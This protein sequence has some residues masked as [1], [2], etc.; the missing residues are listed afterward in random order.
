MFLLT[1]LLFICE[2][3]KV[4]VH[5]N[6]EAVT[7]YV[8][9]WDVCNNIMAYKLQ[10]RLQ[11]NTYIAIFLSPRVYSC[12]SIFLCS[13]YVILMNSASNFVGRMLAG[14]C[15]LQEFLHRFY[16]TRLGT[17]FQ[18]TI[19]F[20]YWWIVINRS[21]HLDNTTRYVF[22]KQ[23]DCCWMMFHEIW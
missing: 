2:I 3:M 15:K 9:V 12:F 18:H 10:N 17:I 21:I 4:R 23:F 7:Y 22:Y 14:R 8:L 11:Y 19:C 20:S 16:M 13:T 1:A 6:H 5:H